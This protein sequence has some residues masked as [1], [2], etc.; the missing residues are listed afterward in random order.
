MAPSGSS[1]GG[2]TDPTLIRS[3]DLS[4]TE[5]DVLLALVRRKLRDEYGWTR[6][7]KRYFGVPAVYSLEQ[8]RYVDAEG[9]VCT[10][11]PDQLEGGKLDCAGGLGAAMHVTASFG[12]VM[13]Q[14]TLE[15]LLA[16]RT[17][18]TG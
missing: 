5:H 14:R 12:M 16:R 17:D 13:V 7:P 1:A 18:A 10:A 11:K 3:R 9:R 6:N 2:R 8:V 15:R 4:K